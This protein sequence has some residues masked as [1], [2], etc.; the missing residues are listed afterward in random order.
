MEVG[1]NYLFMTMTFYWTGR[2]VAI[3]PADITIDDAA[4]VFDTGELETTLKSGEVNICQA[5]PGGTL[6]TIPRNGTTAIEWKPNL[7]RKS[8]RG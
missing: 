5:I 2:V 8:K 3:T 7:I 1:Q 4:Q 6:V